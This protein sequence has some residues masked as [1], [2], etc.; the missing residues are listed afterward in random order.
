[1][2][3][4]MVSLKMVCAGIGWPANETSEKFLVTLLFKTN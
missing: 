3:C 4:G 1:M 2:A